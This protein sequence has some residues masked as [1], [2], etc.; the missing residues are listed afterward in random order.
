MISVTPEQLR[1]QARVYT[2]AREQID[3]ANQRVRRMNDEIAA[4]WKGRAFESYLTQYEQLNKHV[5][6]FKNLLGDIHKQLNMY[7]ETAAQRDAEDARRFG[8]S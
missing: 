7:A 3:Q 2:E 5:V 8:L 4:Q 6:E 1:S